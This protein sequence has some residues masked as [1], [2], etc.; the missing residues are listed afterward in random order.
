MGS[1]L[2]LRGMREIKNGEWA[3]IFL[4]TFRYNCGNI[5]KDWSAY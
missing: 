4:L 2:D 1:I 3:K 5:L